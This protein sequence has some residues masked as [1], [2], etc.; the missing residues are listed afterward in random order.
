MYLPKHFEETR[1]E[2]LHEHIRKHPLATIVTL[3]STGLEA[4]HIPLVLDSQGSDLGILRG[5]VARANSLW[6]EFN[7]EVETLAIFQ[8]PDSY[9]S[10]SWYPSKNEHGKVVPTWNYAV[11]H[12]RGSLKVIED[13]EWLLKL[14]EKTTLEHEGQRD[15]P[16]RV[17]DAPA[18]FVE[19]L[20]GAIVGIEL[21]ITSLTGKW[22]V[23]Q[24]QKPID[25]AGVIEGL[26]NEGTADAL[27]MAE[28]V[29]KQKSREL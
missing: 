29:Q 9:I 17:S 5:H 7:T 15:V 8:G 4:N 18:D 1:I 16:W 13:T 26:R 6:R 21:Q 22:K 28:L 2:V 27:A 25:H 19:K 10:P 3:T 24:N 20:L 11:V 23:S 14:L 12:A